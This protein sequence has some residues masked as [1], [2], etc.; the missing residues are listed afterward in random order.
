MAGRLRISVLAMR[1]GHFQWRGYARQDR[2]RYRSYA[3]LDNANRLNFDWSLIQAFLAVVEHGAVARAAEA[4]GATQP[5]LSRQIAALEAEIGAAL[6]TRGARG[7]VLTAAGEALVYPAKQMQQA[8]HAL[9]LAAS[10]QSQS[11][12]G[13]VRI[14]ASEMTSAF[15]LPPILA[16]LRWKYPDIQLEIVANNAQDNLLE[17]EA[18]IAVRMAKPEQDSLVARHLGGLKMGGFASKAYLDQKNVPFSPATMGDFDWI[19]Y[20]KNPAIVNSCRALGIE[21]TRESFAVR[22]DD[23]MVCW[24]AMLNGM[25]IGFAFE[26]LAKQYPQLVRVLPENWIKDSPV[27]LTAPLELRSNPRIRVVYDHLAEHLI[28]LINNQKN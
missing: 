4:I 18:D 2:Y 6:F 11:L 26:L 14:T 7:S 13:T 8:A 5:T 28:A 17:R 21:L 27:W 23:Q 22:S 25:G 24:Q 9:Q 15:L 10:G 16:S 3:K 12:K 20:D 1:W 19:G